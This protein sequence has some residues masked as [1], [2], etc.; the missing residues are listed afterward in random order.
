MLLVEAVL[1]M[2]LLGELKVGLDVSATLN[3]T[4]VDIRLESALS[5][6]QYVITDKRYG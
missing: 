6:N 2:A 4:V 1:A 5:Q 3:Q